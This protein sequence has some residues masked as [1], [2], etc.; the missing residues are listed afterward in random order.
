MDLMKTTELILMSDVDFSFLIPFIN[1]ER[2]MGSGSSAP[3]TP[4]TCDLN[5]SGPVGKQQEGPAGRSFV[6]P[7]INSQNQR[8]FFGSKVVDKGSPAAGSLTL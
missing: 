3:S 2:G 1:H 7:V 4:G 5:T 8:R 6:S